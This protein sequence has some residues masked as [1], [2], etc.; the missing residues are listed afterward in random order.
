MIQSRVF[1][2]FPPQSRGIF[3]KEK[4]PY[5]PKEGEYLL[6]HNRS[7]LLLALKALHLSQGSKVGVMAYNCHTVMNAVPDAGG[8]ICFLDVTHDLRLDLD[9]LKRKKEN[10]AAIIVSHLF[11]LPNDIEAIREICPQV[12]IIEDCAHAFG[13]EQCGVHGDFAVYSVGPGK[14]PSIGD[15]GIL[16]VNNKQYV[17]AIEQLYSTLPDYSSGHEIRLFAELFVLHLL[18]KP[19][20]YSY[21]TMPF[22]KRDTK[23]TPAAREVIHPRKMA[24][25][26]ASVYNA[27]LSK[28]ENQKLQQQETAKALN[29]FFSKTKGIHIINKYPSDSNC[30]MYP[31]YCDNPSLLKK[32]LL[33]KGIETE[34]HFKHCI[35][36]AKSFGY[37]EG[38]CPNAEYLTKH[39]LMIPTYK[40]L[41]L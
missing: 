19:I 12:P 21:F 22:L 38:D 6:N 14:F 24:R 20:I 11:G 29:S 15:G 37:N 32:E 35:E 10:L 31:L 40:P 8:T 30:F 41:N 17:P 39:L 33:D 28:T 3:L 26:I 13:M 1:F 18:H 34:T 5:R 2:S 23:K 7:G 27:A 16:R 9:D 25:G 36:W 4:M